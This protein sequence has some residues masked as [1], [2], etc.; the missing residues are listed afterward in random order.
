MTLKN[1]NI[2]IEYKDAKTPEKQQVEK[3]RER[4]LL[5]KAV[6]QPLGL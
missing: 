5:T 6:V 1:Y 3:T 2:I 4:V